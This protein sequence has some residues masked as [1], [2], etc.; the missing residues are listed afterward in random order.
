MLPRKVT[1]RDASGD[2]SEHLRPI[3][4]LPE[5]LRATLELLGESYQTVAEAGEKWFSDLRDSP[6]HNRDKFPTRTTL[7][8]WCNGERPTFN[9]QRL[10]VLCA[11]LRYGR[12]Q[13][14]LPS[15]YASVCMGMAKRF[16]SAPTP[17]HFQID[18]ALPRA[19]KPNR[20]V[21]N[22]AD[23]P[24]PGEAEISDLLRTAILAIKSAQSEIGKKLDLLRDAPIKVGI[25]FQQYETV[26]GQYTTDFDTFV[27]SVAR[28]V[29]IDKYGDE[30]HFEGEESLK[31]YSGGF[32]RWTKRFCVLADMMD[33]TDIA[34]MDINMWCSATVLYDSLRSRILGSVVGFPSGRMCVARED[35]EDAWFTSD[36]SGVFPAEDKKN[37]LEGTSGLTDIRQARIG[38]Y[39]QKPLNFLKTVSDAAFIEMISRV[40]AEQSGE[41]ALRLFNFAGNPMIIKLVDRSRANDHPVADGM[42]AIFEKRGQRPHDFVPSAY[43]ALKMKAAMYDLDEIPITEDDLAE[44]VRYPDNRAKA[45]VIA[46]SD[47]LAVVLA[48]N[49][50]ADNRFT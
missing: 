8:N 48:R 9:V 46:A 18:Y 13:Q 50:S 20:F 31:K 43:I 24:Q 33:G 29:F 10:F 1:A 45:Y 27:E 12:Y 3:G 30:I 38:F 25:D 6:F 14:P 21:R 28:R 17:W 41:P 36:E 32:D 11:Y 4:K 37:V 22:S 39:G 42:D 15:N 35:R 34:A 26:K 49:L 7:E 44:T 2:D 23:V 47:N 19:H 5:N 40:E 16:V